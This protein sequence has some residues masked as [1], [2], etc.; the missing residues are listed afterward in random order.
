[1]LSSVVGGKQQM[2]GSEIPRYERPAACEGAQT[3]AVGL[4][5]ENRLPAVPRN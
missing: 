4:E 1:V 2:R 3:H 5:T